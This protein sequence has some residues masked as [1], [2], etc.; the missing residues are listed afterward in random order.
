MARWATYIVG[1]AALFLFLTWGYGDVLARAEQESYISDSA[2]TMHGM[3]RL[4][5]GGIYWVGR[6]ALVVY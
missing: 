4:P 5:M 1:F 2:D 6:W 3:Q